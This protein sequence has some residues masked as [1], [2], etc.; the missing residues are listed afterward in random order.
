MLFCDRT[1]EG[2]KGAM[3]QRAF[4]TGGSAM[5]STGFPRSGAWSN[6]LT[7]VRRHA[8]SKS[9][10][11]RVVGRGVSKRFTVP[12]PRRPSRAFAGM[13]ST[14]LSHRDIEE[15]MKESGFSIDDTALC[16]RV[17]FYAPEPE[18]CHSA[19][20]VGTDTPSIFQ[21]FILRIGYMCTWVKGTGRDQCLRGRI[22][23]AVAIEGR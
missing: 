16:R 9:A 10:P 23:V 1:K 22:S 13:A 14:P 6:F 3:S 20:S 15:I 17:Q 4:V 5:P 19:K 7:S 12:H 18:K 21:T 11:V 2:P 8:R